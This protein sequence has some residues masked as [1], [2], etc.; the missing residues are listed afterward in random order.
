MLLPM[1]KRRTSGISIERIV[2]GGQTG[3]DRGALD[4]A[5]ALGIPHGGWCPRGRLAEDGVI[6]ARYLLTETRSAQYRHRT[7]R[8]V[9]DSDGTLIVFRRTLSGGTALTRQ[10]ALRLAK[11]LCMIDLDLEV[12]VAA[13]RDWVEQHQIR[14]LN[15]AGPRESSWPGVG[16]QT[17]ALITMLL[18]GPPRSRSLQESS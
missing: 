9:A 10:I 17:T 16:A 14:V 1:T 2:S 3:V 18:G 13:T 15:V 8:N 4:A 11:P 12:D 5:M 6:P 7:E